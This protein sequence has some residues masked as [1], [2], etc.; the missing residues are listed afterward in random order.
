MVITDLDL[1]YKVKEIDFNKLFSS[2]A[3]YEIIYLF[4]TI[5]ILKDWNIY[6]VDVKTAYLYDDLNNKIVRITNI[7]LSFYFIFELRIRV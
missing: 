5:A 2:V 3:C 1:L 7:R 6:N 4:L